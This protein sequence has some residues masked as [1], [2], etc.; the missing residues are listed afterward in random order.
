MSRSAIRAFEIL[1]V[2]ITSPRGLKHGEIALA[3]DIPKGSLTKLI[4]NLLDKAYLEL[5]PISKLYTIGPQVL[6]L[7]NAYLGNLDIVK[8][9]QPVIYEAMT[10]TGESASFF[11]KRGHI[12][13]VISKENS[14]HMLSAMLNVGESVPLYATAGGKALLAYLSD[15]ELVDYLSAVPLTPLTPMTIT[16]SVRLRRE[17]DKIRE[18]GFAYSNGEQFEDLVAIAAPVFGL[19]EKVVA[20]I[21]LPFPK[22]RFN[23][24][25]KSIIEKTLYA[26][27]IAISKKL[28]IDSSALLPKV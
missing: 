26:S 2:L 11:I 22:S 17:L 7:A 21:S 25:K 23:E 8:M 13:L 16:D 14:P 1:E 10:K 12:G 15:A 20:A 5:D 24:E 19:Y 27:S 9:A 3:L 28:G 6:A 4:K 18:V